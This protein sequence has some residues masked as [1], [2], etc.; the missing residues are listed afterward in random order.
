MNDFKLNPG[1]ILV[2][3]NDRHDLL[4]TIKRWAAGPYE[5]V[6]IYMGKVGLFINRR[7]RRIIRIPMLF[8]SDGDGAI[9][10][11]LSSRYGQEV[12]VLRLISE[13]DRRRIPRVLEE[14]IKLA[15]DPQSHYDYLCIV[16]YVLPRLILE[17]LGLPVWVLSHL[18]LAWQRDRRQI[19]SEAVFEIFDR[20]KLVDILPLYCR[21]PMPGDFVTDSLLLEEVWAGVLSEGLLQSDS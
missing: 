17:K 12:T 18:P 3:V 14:A 2:N 8:E 13:F 1:D 6:F 21:P 16:K 4:S 11:S 7:Q 5:H 9:I 10:E 15:D 20:A 19:C